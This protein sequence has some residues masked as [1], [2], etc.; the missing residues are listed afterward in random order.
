LVVQALVGGVVALLLIFLVRPVALRHL[1]PAREVRTGT[2]ALIGS[3]G[4]VLER[5]DAHDGRVRLAGEVWS[6]RSL[7]PTRAFEPGDTV[8]V[9][10]IEGATAVVN[11]TEKGTP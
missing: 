11:I 1:H 3:E 10:R 5:I 9:S 4:L 8:Q 6:A 2:A 7:D